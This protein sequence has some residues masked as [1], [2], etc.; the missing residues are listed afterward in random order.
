MKKYISIIFI[1]ISLFQTS[2][3]KAQKLYVNAGIGY[4]FALSPM[5]F[6]VNYSSAS[7]EEVSGSCG[8]GVLPNLGLGYFLNEHISFEINANYLAGHKIEFSTGYS[9]FAPKETEILKSQ[10]LRI[11]P[12]LKITAGHG[13]NPYLRFGFVIGVFNRL[14][15]EYNY[16]EP[17]STGYDTYQTVNVFKGGASYGFSGAAG[18]DFTFS[19][20]LDIFAELGTISQGWAPKK[21]VRE[22][23]DINGVNKLATLDQRDIE[24]DFVDSYNPNT[25]IQPNENNKALKIH[26]PFSSWGFNAGVKIKFGKKKE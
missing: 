3:V 12:A 20:N 25:T 8:K 16:Y 2:S 11:I 17:S 9:N 13:V 15:D 7:V 24:T 5:A 19:D 21:S 26:L 1:A 6:S 14:H 22:T 23:Y 10:M 4:G 18:V